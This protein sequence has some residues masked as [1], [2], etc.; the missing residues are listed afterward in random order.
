MAGILDFIDQNLGTRLGL[1]VNDPKA[2]MQQMNQQAG[3]YNQASM[4]ATQAERNAMRGLPVTPEQAQ[5]KQYVDKIT[6]DLAMGFAGTTIGKGSFKYPQAEALRLAQERAALPI[7]KGGLGLPADNT[8]MDRAKAM[9]FNVP[10]YHG[11]NADIVAMS[12]AGK[13]KT[14]GAGAFVT[15]NPIAAE[16]YLGGVGQG[17]NIIPLLLREQNLLT[18]NAR[19][20]NWNDID[21]NIL[22]SKGKDLIDIL[23]LDRNAG[24]STDELAMLAKDAGFSGIKLKNIKDLGPNSHVLRAKEY[25]KDK[26]NIYPDETWSN[27]S[28]KQFVE[29][30]DYLDKF[31]KKQKS[32][33]TAI[34]DADLLRSRFAAF[35]P[36]RKTSAIAATMG[37]AAPDLLAGEVPL[38]LLA[39]PNVEMPKKDKRK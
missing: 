11:T 19:G 15:S 20:R 6:E 27:V 5:A 18:T 28:E 8:A 7:N 31:Y 3:A 37:L 29:S 25:L 13:G 2:A 22:K 35:D 24:T 34:N 4:L 9:G 10:V 30:R 39:R 23:G 33:V 12:T 1:L 26:Y 17:G 38:G 36:F 16:T 21:T 32:D 14:S